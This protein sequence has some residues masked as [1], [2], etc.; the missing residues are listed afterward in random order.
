[1]TQVIQ[2]DLY[3]AVAQKDPI[4]ERTYIYSDGSTRRTFQVASAVTPFD[5]MELLDIG[6]NMVVAAIKAK[7]PK[8]DMEKIK[9]TKDIDMIINIL[10]N[11]FN[12]YLN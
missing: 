7:V 4:P 11:H 3:G 9:D 5:M 8:E 2:K 12:Q 1:M 6:A 10:A